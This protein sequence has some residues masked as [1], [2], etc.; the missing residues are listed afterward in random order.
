MFAYCSNVKEINLGKLDFSLVTDF[1]HMF[2]GCNN[3]VNLDVTNF[4]TKN[5]KS[6]FQMFRYCYNLKKIDV[7]KFNSSKCETIYAM[8][9]NCKSITEI[10]M[11]NWDMS[12][13]KYEGEY[14]KVNPIDYLFLRCSNLKTIKI[15]GNLKKE[16]A[17]K[18]FRGEIFRDV[19]E[20]GVLINKKGV[21]CNIPLDGYLPQSW[22]RSKE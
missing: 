4:N 16:E 10:D 13:L 18:D 11:I 6:F 22:D 15:S 5:S 3:L 19:P 8:F 2:H 17:N 21:K 12:N 14:H 1:S 7:S 20:N 9:Y